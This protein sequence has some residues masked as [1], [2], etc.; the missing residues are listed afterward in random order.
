M[1]S[2]QI[3]V[4]SIYNIIDLLTTTIPHM[5]I[6]LDSQM[7]GLSRH[8][9]TLLKGYGKKKQQQVNTKNLRVIHDMPRITRMER[10]IQSVRS[11][12]VCR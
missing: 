12:I 4:I 3:E 10:R 1:K 9:R 6:M 5:S 2:L 8:N 11:S 7:E